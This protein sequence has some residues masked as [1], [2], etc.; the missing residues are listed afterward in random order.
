MDV[1][2]VAEAHALTFIEPAVGGERIIVSAHAFKWQDLSKDSND[3]CCMGTHTDSA[4]VL[5]ARKIEG[6]KIPAGNTSYD[7]SKAKHIQV[8]ADKGRQMLG[9]KYHTLEE[10]TRHMLH[11]FKCRGWI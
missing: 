8:I 10:T 5:V 7:P 3:A 9:L 4:T 2:D 6:D 1:R 11:E